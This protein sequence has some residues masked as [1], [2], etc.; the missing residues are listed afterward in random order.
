MKKN[1][2]KAAIFSLT[3]IM[4][5]AFAGQALST[6]GNNPF[7]VSAQTVTV[8]RKSRPGVIRRTYRGGRY[9]I[10]KTWN[11]TRWVSRR[12]WVATK[13]TGKKAWRGT[14]KVGRTV[15]RVV[16]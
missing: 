5:I 4:S 6:T 7:S 10:R 1:K 13:W 11:G 2:I 14:R 9:V 12:V 3:M 8:K 15:K 16:Y